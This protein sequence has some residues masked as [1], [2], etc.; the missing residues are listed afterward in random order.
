MALTRPHQQYQLTDP[1]PLGIIVKEEVQCRICR[2][3]DK[4]ET[5]YH[6][7]RDCL[8]LWRKRWEATGYY[9]YNDDDVL[10]W[11]PKALAGYFDSIDLENK[12]N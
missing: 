11:D 7:A 9:T 10:N 6:I 8:P 3:E 1:E 12:P 5:P 2:R 4:E